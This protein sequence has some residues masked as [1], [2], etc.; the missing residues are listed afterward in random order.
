MP[1]VPKKTLPEEKVRVP[2]SRKV[3]VPPAKG[4]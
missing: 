4:I 2:V 3:A 1:A